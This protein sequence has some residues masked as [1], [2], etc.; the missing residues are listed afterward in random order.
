MTNFEYYL[1]VT[2]LWPQSLLDL[3]PTRATGQRA[4][5]DAQPPWARLENIP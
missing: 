4:E 3:S 5:T 2:D 1:Q